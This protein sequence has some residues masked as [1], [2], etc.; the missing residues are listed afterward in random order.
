MMQGSYLCM[1]GSWLYLELDQLATAACQLLL[2]D[3]TKAEWQ[4]YLPN[5]P[6]RA[7]CP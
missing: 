5:L 1:I 6:Y 7:T 2:R 3:L 4:T